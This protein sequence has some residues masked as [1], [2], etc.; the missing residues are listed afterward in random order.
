MAG[1][2]AGSVWT[3]TRKHIQANVDEDQ[4][5]RHHPTWMDPT[6]FFKGLFLRAVAGMPFFSH[7]RQ[8]PRTDKG[9]VGMKGSSTR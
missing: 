6:F 3:K 2:N 8:N 9:F 1:K 4:L 7:T 5:T